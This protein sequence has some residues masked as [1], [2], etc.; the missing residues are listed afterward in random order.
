MSSF[1]DLCFLELSLFLG[2]PASLR[3][4]RWL[5]WSSQTTRRMEAHMI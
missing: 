1:D 3:G 4:R 5:G 2:R